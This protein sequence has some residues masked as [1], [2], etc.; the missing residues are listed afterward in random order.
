[1][2]AAEKIASYAEDFSVSF[3]QT[4]LAILLRLPGV[5]DRTR[6]LV[7]W[8]YFES[9][10][11]QAIAKAS[12]YYFDKYHKLPSK[13]IIDKL[14]RKN[15][16]RAVIRVELNRLWNVS[17]DSEEFVEDNIR[18]FARKQALK[19]AILT[20]IDTL[21]HDDSPNFE[22]ISVSFERALQVGNVDITEAYDYFPTTKDRLRALRDLQRNV[23]PLPTGFKGVDR[24]I[25]G[26]LA[27]KQLGV[28]LAPSN[29]GKSGILAIMAKNA[30]A[31]SKHVLVVTLEMPVELWAQRLDQTISGLTDRQLMTQDI[32]QTWKRISKFEKRFKGKI[33]IVEFPARQLTVPGLKS[34][35][36]EAGRDRPVD[37]VILDYADLMRSP[38][39]GGNDGN[40]IAQGSIYE[41]LHGML[42]TV[43]T[44]LW[45]GCQTGRQGLNKAIIRLDDIG[46]S[47]R[48]ANI[49]D[50]VVA[51]CQTEAEEQQKMIRMFM[52]KNRV[53][54][55]KMIVGHF[56]TQWET[57]RIKEHEFE[58]ES[59]IAD[60]RKSASASGLVEDD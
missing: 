45:T 26:G 33:T 60:P 4:V 9:E 16:Q 37:L 6:A 46:E 57:M 58:G 1:M 40:W 47:W 10:I 7:Q 35:I 12:L 53:G 5:L 29:G 51:I 41:H 44:R 21:Q 20:A 23:E 27:P 8:G 3:Q 39:E 32:E 25:R 30:A 17:L 11:H 42:K 13:A 56:K 22:D 36:M 31:R 43:Q 49:S 19:G 59:P 14:C 24:N 28:I 2:L 15:A 54:P 50:V 38:S 48:K 52:A 55:S 18:S 34:T